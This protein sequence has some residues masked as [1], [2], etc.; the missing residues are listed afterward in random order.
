MNRI[1]NIKNHIVSINVCITM[2]I[3]LSDCAN[4]DLSDPKIPF[5]VPTELKAEKLSATS[6]KLSWTDNSKGEDGFSI[7]R[8]VT[9]ATTPVK[10]TVGANT[11]EWTDEGLVQATYLYKVYAFCKQ[12]ASDTVSVYYQHV[13]VAM[14]AN[15]AVVANQNSVN[16][17]WDAV[18]GGIDG[19][20][21]E[22]KIG[23]GTFQSWKTLAANEITV[24]D[25]D[26]AAGLN[27]Y[28]LYAY[29][30]SATSVG[31][32]RSLTILKTPVIAI[33]S[34]KV[35]YLKISSYFTLTS[36]GGEPCTAGLC[37][38]KSSNPTIA[39]S[40]SAW[41][42]KVKSGETFFGNASSLDANTNYYVRAYATNSQ[43][44]TYSSEVQGT[45][46]A[47]PA[48]LS[49]TWTAM[50][51]INAGLPTEIK[52]YT[53]TSS[54]NGRAFQAWYAIADLSTGNIELKTTLSTTAQKPSQFIAAA[55]GETTYVMTNGGYFGYSGSNVSSY[56]LAVDRNSKK[57]DNISA[58][59]RG[60]Y[61][62]PVTRGAFGVSQSQS[63]MLRWISGDN[64]YDIPSP[65][66]EGETPQI[67][68]SQSFP[69]N[70]VRW[71]P[72]SAIGGAP[73]LIKDGK[74]V[75]DFTTTTAGKYM[76]NYELLQ[77]DIFSSS[78]R[79]PRTLIG[80]TADNKVVLFVCD[81]RQA[82]SD[83]ATLLELVQIMKAIGCTNVLNL[84]GGG[85]S[86]IIASGTLLNKPSDGTERAVATVVSFV[87]KK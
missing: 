27:T 87:K 28:K 42:V 22:R 29:A 40:K 15:F 85:S 8:W 23:A 11:T 49:L 71:N 43:G 9:G 69:I 70:T 86:A 10:A 25:T 48:T 68:P 64:A 30:G 61:S 12:R 13:P 52:V 72:Y 4:P 17:S 7:E 60:S 32:E 55:T 16:L 45:L 73:I 46:A 57:A 20:N 33:A 56:S 5:P 80:S 62:Y 19:Y 76:T 26:P 34:P 50:T 3:A 36:D 59:T 67:S 38:S 44:T 75:F 47:E 53:T 6:I 35:S 14:P 83:G 65:N 1:M 63:P 37:W 58:L 24:T 54:L 66:V 39:D 78:A 77:T 82:H 41:H 2:L 31:V 79:P 81:G 74:P 84:D 51:S 21:I 18:T